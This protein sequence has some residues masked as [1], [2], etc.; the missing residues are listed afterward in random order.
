MVFSSL[1]LNIQSVNADDDPTPP[2]GE[3]TPTVNPGEN[4]EDATLSGV[5]SEDLEETATEIPGDE[6]EALSSESTP[7]ATN[8][9][10]AEATGEG[11]NCFKLT[12]SHA[13]NGS[14]PSAAPEFSEGCEPGHYTEDELIGL[15]NALAEEGWEISGWS[16]TD[17][18][19]SAENSNTLVMPGN[20]HEVSVIYT[21]IE[22]VEAKM[23]WKQK[24]FTTGEHS[25]TAMW[26]REN[27]APIS[28]PSR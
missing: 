18:N 7:E 16:G 28:R 24:R 6:T 26:Q 2:V 10:T 23:T 3:E 20:D 13:G 4:P 14:D 9:P 8:E 1:S 11:V 12:V 25:T 27:Q 22:D 15:S 19:D 5:I 21:A 17:N